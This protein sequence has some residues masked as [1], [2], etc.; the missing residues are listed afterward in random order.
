[1]LN[2]ASRRT[3]KAN[4]QKRILIFVR[5]DPIYG[6]NVRVVLVLKLFGPVDVRTCSGA[7][8]NVPVGHVQA[9]VNGWLEFLK[10]IPEC[11]RRQKY[12]APLRGLGKPEKDRT[13]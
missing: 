2:P 13:M 4:Y 6:W 3:L 10:G 9:F 1:M 12:I 7:E 5:I 11:I 8:I